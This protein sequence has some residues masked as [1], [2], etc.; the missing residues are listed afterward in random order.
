MYGKFLFLQLIAA[1]R[2]MLLDT[3]TVHPATDYYFNCVRKERKILNRPLPPLQRNEF[4]I[5]FFFFD[6]TTNKQA[7]QERKKFY[8]IL[9]SFYNKI[10]LRVLH[11]ILFK[12]RFSMCHKINSNKHRKDMKHMWAS[13]QQKEMAR[14]HFT[15][16]EKL[17][18]CCWCV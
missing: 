7:R 17:Q 13:K 5:R 10:F 4:L 11:E 9:T 6:S 12:N 14:V 16:C 2:F 15:L 1:H 8:V 18:N 3:H